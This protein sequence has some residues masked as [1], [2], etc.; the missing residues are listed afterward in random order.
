M[1]TQTDLFSRFDG[2]QAA[3]S[4]NA[5]HA[6]PAWAPA[7]MEMSEK[8]R[9]KKLEKKGEHSLADR[10]VG[11]LAVRSCWGRPHYFL[12]NATSEDGKKGDFLLPNHGVLYS[13]LNTVVLGAEM[14]ICYLG[15]DEDWTGKGNAPYMYDVFPANASDIVEGGREDALDLRALEAAAKAKREARQQMTDPGAPDFDPDAY[16]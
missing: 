3:P 9:A 14:M 15:P 4:A 16:E 7:M 12:E 6:G 2:K 10:I 5:G 1:A 13:R 8:R 11:R